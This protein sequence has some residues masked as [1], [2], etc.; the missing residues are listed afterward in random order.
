M[1]YFAGFTDS[2]IADFSYILSQTYNAT[3]VLFNYFYVHAHVLG[4]FFHLIKGSFSQASNHTLVLT[5]RLKLGKKQR[6]LL[7]KGSEKN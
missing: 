1:H 7:M 6:I 5:I 4:K 2:Y 3:L